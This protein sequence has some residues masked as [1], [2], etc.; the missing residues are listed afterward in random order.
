MA[1]PSHA[2]PTAVYREDH[3]AMKHCWHVNRTV[4]DGL[5]KVGTHESYCCFC[6]H[7]ETIE[8]RREH[9]PEHG[10]FYS[11]TVTVSDWPDKPCP[12][13]PD[14]APPEEEP[15]V[16]LSEFV[17]ELKRAAPAEEPPPSDA[18]PPNLDDIL[19]WLSVEAEWWAGDRSL[20][21]EHA[22]TRRFQTNLVWQRLAD[23][24]DTGK[25]P[26]HGLE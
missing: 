19:G 17:E 26:Q 12:K 20:R 1:K 15:T 13:R 8:W 23:W 18:A 10:S 9:P 2:S 22:N 25:E 11:G 5:A 24:R 7:R 6:E 3:E 4:T 21:G 16:R 14:A